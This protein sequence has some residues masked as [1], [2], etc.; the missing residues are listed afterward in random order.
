MTI[1][2]IN[3]KEQK[4]FL[5][6]LKQL[7]ETHRKSIWDA[8]SAWQDDLTG[9]EVEE[10]SFNLDDHIKCLCSLWEVDDEWLD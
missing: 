10:L 4:L 5:F 2:P 9:E 6:V 8:V 7:R 3:N 1:E